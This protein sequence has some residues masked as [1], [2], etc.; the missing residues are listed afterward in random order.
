MKIIFLESVNV[1]NAERAAEL[2]GP[3]VAEIWQK[4]SGEDI[5]QEASSTS[6][7]LKQP[8]VEAA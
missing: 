2:L 5:L 1:P 7:T 3:M 6:E 8:S 4:T